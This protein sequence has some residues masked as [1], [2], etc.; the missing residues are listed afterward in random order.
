[1]ADLNS[2]TTPYEFPLVE[3]I[4]AEVERRAAKSGKPAWDSSLRTKRY[5]RPDG[6]ALR[7]I[8]PEEWATHEWANV[9]SIDDPGDGHVFVRMARPRFPDT[10]RCCCGEHELTP[11]RQ[12][13]RGLGF[14]Q[15]ELQRCVVNDKW[16]TAGA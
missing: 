4:A 1:M 12:V 10:A 7:E 2:R 3:A 6:E 5:V 15:H 16:K 14:E 13:V 11:S 8:T 9:T